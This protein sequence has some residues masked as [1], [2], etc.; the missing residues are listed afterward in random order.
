MS[1]KER[2]TIAI[3]NALAAA[4]AGARTETIAAAAKELDNG[5]E[6]RFQG[7]QTGRMRPFIRSTFTS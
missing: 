5:V 6:G 7:S 1:D 4:V 3:K 2:R